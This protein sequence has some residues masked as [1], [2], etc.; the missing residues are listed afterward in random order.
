LQQ[1]KPVVYFW[2]DSARRRSI[3]YGFTGPVNAISA[4]I[5]ADF[6]SDARF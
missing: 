2:L 1:G 6:S 3:G 4:P 5:A